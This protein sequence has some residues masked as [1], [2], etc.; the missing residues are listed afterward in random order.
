MGSRVGRHH[1]AVPEQISLNLAFLV[2]DLKL[3]S[4]IH[5][6]PYITT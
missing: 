2:A 4:V 6:T 1:T 3:G 5:K